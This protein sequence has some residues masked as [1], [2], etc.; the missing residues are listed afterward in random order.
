ML[1]E[2]KIIQFY[3]AKLHV[4]CDDNGLLK[5]FSHKDFDGLNAEPYTFKSSHGHN[6]QGYFYYYTK[7]TDN[8]LVIFEH[9]FGGGHSS[10]LKEI[11]KLC[12]NGFKVFAY[13]HTGCMESG[14]QSTNG[15]AQSLCDLDDCIKALNA[16]GKTNDKELFIL[17]HSWG[18]YSTLNIS[19]FHN[20][21]KKIVVFAGVVSVQKIIEQF[22]PAFLKGYRNAVFETEKQANPGYA[23]YDGGQTLS[24]SQ[25]KAILIYSDNDPIVKKESHYDYLYS[26]LKDKNNITFLLEKNKGHNPNYTQE[27][28]KALCELSA[29]MKKALK[30]KTTDEKEQFKN[31]FDWDKMTQQD[32]KVWNNVIEFLK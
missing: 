12:A 32:E 20:E 23:N 11:E 6:M 17:G 2:K 9:G 3:K 8:V 28:V 29:S 15:F 7:H 1:L 19:A 18:G 4:R 10:Y 30:L 21:I 22:F 14:G 25:T 13:D 16:D 31:S 24:K 26:N 5:Y 27:A